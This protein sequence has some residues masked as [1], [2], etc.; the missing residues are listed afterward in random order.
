[1]DIFGV[2]CGET[3]ASG[4]GNEGANLRA[5]R[6]V[7]YK[8]ESSEDEKRGGDETEQDRSW[9]KRNSFTKNR[10]KL[11][12]KNLNLPNLN[13]LKK[14]PSTPSKLHSKSTTSNAD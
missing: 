7:S 11:I 5:S 1:M 4:S 9:K 3:R 12:K 10:I 2:G 13:L 8:G 14:S 6:Q